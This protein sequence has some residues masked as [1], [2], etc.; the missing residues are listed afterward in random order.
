MANNI[1]NKYDLLLSEL[2]VLNKA[3]DSK[4]LNNSIKIYNSLRLHAND[5]TLSSIE[6][7]EI[8]Y[9][10]LKAHQ[11]IM[12][13]QN[14][15]EI[16]NSNKN[17]IV[18][19]SSNNVTNI[20]SQ[21]TTNTNK[22]KLNNIIHD[23]S[24]RNIAIGIIFVMLCGIMIVG[25][26]SPTIIQNIT[27]LF[28]NAG[29]IIPPKQE[30]PGTINETNN[31]E[32]NNSIINNNN[33]NISNQTNNTTNISNNTNNQNNISI[34]I[35]NSNTT[36]GNS[37]GGGG[38]S[39][40]GNDEEEPP[41]DT[42]TDG[43][44][45]ENETGIDCGG[46][47][48]ACPK[49]L[50]ENNTGY[51]EIIISPNATNMTQIAANELQTYIYNMTGALLPK[52]YVVNESIQY[53][54]YVGQSNYTD[55]LGIT[56]EGCEFDSFKM[57]SGENYLVLLGNDDL[58][59]TPEPYPWYNEDIPR[60]RAEWRNITNKTWDTPYF[61]Y[62][63]TYN[64]R[65]NIWEAD[66][67]G[68]IN[69]VYE[70][71]YSQGIRWY[72]PGEIGTVIPIRENILLP[73]VNKHIRPDFDARNMFMYNHQ[74]IHET[75]STNYLKWQ[76]RL[77]LNSGEESRGITTGH[78]INAITSPSGVN[79]AHPEYYA[80][81][82]N[83]R[84]DG[85]NGTDQ[86]QDLCS[87]DLL[88]EN[89]DYIKAV[90]AHYNPPSENVMPADGYTQVS[91]SSQECLDK[92]TPDRGNLGIISD[93]VFEYVNNVATAVYETYPNKK[94][95]CSAYGAY[96]LPPLDIDQFS[97]NVAITISRSRASF[98]N[99]VTKE[100][101]QNLTYDWL[102]KLPS[103]TI[104]TYDYYLHNDPDRDYEGIPV[105]FPHIISED[106]KFLNG[107]SKGEF[108]EVAASS[109]GLS[110]DIMA[111][112]SLNVYVTA[113]LYWNSSEDIDDLLDEYYEL[114][115]GPASSEMK[116]FVE[117]SEN[118]LNTMLSDPSVLVNLR[119]MG[120]NARSVAG[121][122]IYGERIDLLLHF[123]N[124]TYIGEEVNISSCQ[125]LT[126]PSTTYRLTANLDSKET[127]FNIQADGI[128]LDC[129][130]HNIT[131]DFEEGT[132]EIGIYSGYDYATVKNCILNGQSI[133][134]T[135]VKNGLIENNTVV[136]S[137]TTGII[138]NVFYDSV[139][140]LNNRIISNSVTGS[141]GGGIYLAGS[142]NSTLLNNI[143]ISSS[144]KGIYL[145]KSP[146][147]TMINNTGVSN[148][149][150]G[151]EFYLMNSTVLTNNTGISNSSRAFWIFISSNN[152]LTSNT[153]TSQLTD[154]LSLYS[155]SS[156]NILINNTGT[157]DSGVGIN[158][159]PENSINNT[160]NGNI[161]QSRTNRG[162][163]LD[164]SQNNILISNTGISNSSNGIYLRN[165]SNNNLT[166][167]TARS[168][169]TY[170]LYM[171]T[172]STNNT[173]TNN[174]AIGIA[175]I[176]IEGS[177]TNS[178]INNIGT[179]STSTGLTISGSTNNTFINN[180]GTSNTSYG[181]YLYNSNNNILTT[182]S[183]IG[184]DTGS[185][186]IHILQSNNTLFIDCKN[187]T[188]VIY[189]VYTLTSTNNTFTNCT[190]N[191]SKESINGANM[192]ITRQWYFKP[193][194]ITT[195]GQPIP[196][197]NITLYNNT[198][199]KIYSNL[200]NS[201]GTI[202]TINITEYINT[203]GVRRYLTPHIVNVTKTGYTANNA[204]YNITTTHNIISSITLT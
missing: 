142:Q 65:N 97:P 111:A 15:T 81:W 172:R 149:D 127:C 201:I 62:H 186:G 32:N 160:L 189:D 171:S 154:G 203:N 199:I 120:N 194:I 148:T 131:Y 27:S 187:I 133:V 130:G 196:N 101:Y 99:P 19:Q 90:F 39:S 28:S 42:C 24:K 41:I 197:A 110:Y 60:A 152:I 188:G 6:R 158:L 67:R 78:G 195:L 1:N 11:K 159:I 109:A 48:I 176:L 192:Y 161:G 4:N 116:E 166:N 64:S 7:S 91:N 36:Y 98:S 16:T 175:G 105:Y 25:V 193:A 89:I 73:V 37:G 82:G 18:T 68:S 200:T 22:N 59:D 2:D 12:L 147:S 54:I 164:F 30:I 80:I 103:E 29:Q 83:V 21:T 74:F 108:I 77:R 40:G 75:S 124:A 141:T 86:K 31:T 87:Q 191:N 162:I 63:K 184:Y 5:A 61:L 93:Y 136:N 95:G 88:N 57:V 113:R 52:R 168:N 156:N 150:N 92:S 181:L 117:Y 132:N 38:G 163:Y 119:E 185:R 45:N 170:G 46:N 50:V 182:Q 35:N 143:G 139:P 76:L 85:T 34:Y 179:G 66:G 173:L 13:L 165:S 100:F 112:N 123:M 155:F 9:R 140:S 106:L 135:G 190:Y 115:Y 33:T 183:A 144:G 69:A 169:L 122:T 126:S 84:M 178:L 151:I 26:T 204:I 96:L 202:N 55:A 71:L 145:F 49:Y 14:N 129:Q 102:E 118:N 121:D 56:D 114:Y 44:Q 47:C 174:N 167:N 177:D 10:G 180:S 138:V 72:H 107:K 23:S 51:A 43:I 125:N 94:V 137:S 58:K 104:Y 70:F 198:G 128:T 53:H 3:I 157:S 134:F 79:L 153:G 17:T 20:P 8:Y 146:N